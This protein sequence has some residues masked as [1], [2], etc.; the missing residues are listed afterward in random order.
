M[1][2]VEKTPAID[3]QE[4]ADE[5]AVLRHALE[6]MPLDPEV[7]RRVEQRAQAITERVRREYGDVDVVQLIRDVRS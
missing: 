2:T 5:Q 7:Y 6:R 4:L 3:P 1:S